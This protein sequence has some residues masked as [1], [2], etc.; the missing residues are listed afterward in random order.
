MYLGRKRGGIPRLYY[1]PRWNENGQGQDGGHPGLANPTV[2][3]RCPMISW[4][5]KLLQATHIRI[6]QGQSRINRIDERR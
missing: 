6:L 2:P 1:H 3:E 4:V 5:S